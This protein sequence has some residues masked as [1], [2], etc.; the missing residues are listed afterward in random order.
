M[1]TYDDV[2][3]IARTYL[4]DFPRFFQT[5]FT[6]AGRTYQL[7]H[8]NVDA[9][10]LY[11]ATYTSG[12]ASASVLAADVGYSLDVRNGVIRLASTPTVGAELLLEGSYYE[13]VTPDD[14]L[15]YT[16]RAIEKHL[17]ALETSLESL[18][19]VVIN[20]I[21]IAAIVECGWMAWQTWCKSFC[22]CDS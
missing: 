6:T 12:S 13:W 5:N 2:A 11:V 10:S 1:A 22:S 21:G 20:A 4:R 3:T 9:S 14:L 15:F 18:T 16:H 8:T 19:E 7:G 17:M